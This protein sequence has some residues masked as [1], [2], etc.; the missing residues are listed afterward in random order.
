MEMRRR[1]I[2]DFI[3]RGGVGRGAGGVWDGVLGG[4]GV[5]SVVWDRVCGND[6]LVLGDS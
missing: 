3:E 4:D 5:G 2:R 6:G 1:V